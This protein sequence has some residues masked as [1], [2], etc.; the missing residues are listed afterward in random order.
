MSN[1]IAM[2]FPVFHGEHQVVQ[3]QLT[4]LKQMLCDLE[5]IA[6]KIRGKY[7]YKYPY[8]DMSS[9]EMLFES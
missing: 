2:H 9:S 3:E 1:R 8:H 7:N 6:T 4:A 5:E